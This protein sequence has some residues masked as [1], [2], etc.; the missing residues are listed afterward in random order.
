MTILTYGFEKNQ[1]DVIR[2]MFGKADYIDVTDSY[3]DIFALNA[4][5]VVVN[6]E[7]TA[8][9][10]RKKIYAYEEEMKELENRTYRYIFKEEF[11]GMQKAFYENLHDAIV[12]A[13]RGMTKDEL[14]RLSLFYIHQNDA[15]YIAGIWSDENKDRMYIE[16]YRPELQTTELIIFSFGEDISKDECDYWQ[17]SG[18]YDR[19]SV[20]WYKEAVKEYCLGDLFYDPVDVSE[21][22]PVLQPLKL[23][24]ER[25]TEKYEYAY[26]GD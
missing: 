1:M 20:D 14:F 6:L 26:W 7:N 19:V 12:E 22:H 10:V 8:T 23:K 2:W 15:G 4:D 16:F 9:D 3:Q 25:L 13:S 5:V 21:L 11:S 17:K 24:L 18:H